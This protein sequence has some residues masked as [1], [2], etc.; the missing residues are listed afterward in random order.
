MR[1]E[2]GLPPQR[3]PGGHGGA[4]RGDREAPGEITGRG[5][6]C[7]PETHPGECTASREVEKDSPPASRHLPAWGG[8]REQDPTCTT[9]HSDAGSGTVK[10]ETDRTGSTLTAGLHLGLDCGR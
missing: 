4:G 9:P 1:G 3:P 2:G 7:E 8:G 5:A 6:E 10:E